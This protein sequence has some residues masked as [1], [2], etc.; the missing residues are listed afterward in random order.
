MHSFLLR[1]TICIM[2]ISTVPVYDMFDE[3]NK[4]SLSNYASESETLVENILSPELF[5]NPLAS[6]PPTLPVSTTEFLIRSA[7]PN[8]SPKVNISLTALDTKM[9]INID[10]LLDCGATELFLD[11]DFV[12]RTGLTTRR[13]SSALPIYNVD[14]TLNESGSVKE[15]VDLMISYNGHRERATFY[16]T[17]L[18]F[19]DCILGLP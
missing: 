7:N 9:R 6:T 19:T 14:G 5:S 18:G 1:P 15:A 17:N 8:R 11:S 12:E 4:D 13:L 16:V 3:L 2:R 10:S